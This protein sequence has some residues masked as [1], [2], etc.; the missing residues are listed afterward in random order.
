[1]CKT[2][3]SFQLGISIWNRKSCELFC[4]QIAFRDL[5]GILK[6]IFSVEFFRVHKY[7]KGV[8]YSKYVKPVTNRL[9][10]FNRQFISNR[11]D[12]L[13]QTTRIICTSKRNN[14][15]SK[16]FKIIL[17][18][19]I[20]IFIKL[21]NDQVIFFI[22]QIFIQIILTKKKTRISTKNIQRNIQAQKKTRI[23]HTKK[24]GHNPHWC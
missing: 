2:N 7:L 13:F 10:A 22:R 18:W 20:W 17:N 3:K 1:M 5:C 12:V 16:G 6:W 4:I 11:T 9:T 23:N 24:K 8:K 14:I 21:Q 19:I 15:N